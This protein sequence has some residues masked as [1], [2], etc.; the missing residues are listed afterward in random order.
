MEILF[1][2]DNHNQC[3]PQNTTTVTRDLHRCPVLFI[4]QLPFPVDYTG[5]VTEYVVLMKC[6]EQLFTQVPKYLY[7]PTSEKGKKQKTPLCEALD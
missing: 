6:H 3:N 4:A 1:Y 7:P 5:P 2:N